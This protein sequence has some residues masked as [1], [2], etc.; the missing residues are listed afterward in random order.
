MSELE[1]ISPEIVTV[2][3][4]DDQVVIT[5]F[6]SS[7]LDYFK[8]HFPQAAIL[9]GVVQLDWAVQFARDNFQL[10]NTPLSHVEV[11]KFKAVIFPDSTIT[12]TLIKKSE[13]KYSFD[14]S[15]EVDKHAS[16]RLVFNR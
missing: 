4:E 7:Q 3:R 15:S 9:P 11:L 12:L 5:L 6:V 14:I 2:T 8:G 16:G 10:A 13:Q 1:N